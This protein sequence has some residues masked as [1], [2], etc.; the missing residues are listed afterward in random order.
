MACLA[1]AEVDAAP[2]PYQ[3]Q[4]PRFEVWTEPLVA[5]GSAAWNATGNAATLILPVG[6]EYELTPSTALHL[7]ASWLYADDHQGAYRT[8]GF[9]AALGFQWRFAH[10]GRWTFFLEPRLVGGGLH[11]SLKG[12]SS[13]RVCRD[14]DGCYVDTVAQEIGFGLVAGA[15][16][17]LHGV[18]LS[19]VI[20]GQV[21]WY[22]G[23]EMSV[24]GLTM[25]SLAEGS[26]ASPSGWAITPNLSLVRLGVAF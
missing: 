6:F 19:G 15:S 16:V 20:G 22:S 23:A 4:P 18:Y 21:T 10:A 12:P 5:T 2:S 24:V 3:A 11:Q 14:D 13:A 1:V 9:I 8:N 26:Q 25:L 17:V 7:E